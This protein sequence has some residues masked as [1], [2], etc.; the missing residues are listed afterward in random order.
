MTTL[1]K[2]SAA[3][4]TVTILAAS[5]LATSGDALAKGKQRAPKFGGPMAMFGAPPMGSPL[6]Q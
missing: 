4:L 2:L 1:R 5:S 6:G 3:A